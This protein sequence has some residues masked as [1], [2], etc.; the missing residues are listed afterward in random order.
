[1]IDINN[2]KLK[3]VLIELLDEI[4][5]IC[6][7]NNLTYFLYAGSLLGA[8]RH[9]GF[10]PWDDDIDIAMPRKDYDLFLDLFE[11]QENTN[12]Y[13]LSYKSNNKASRYCTHFGKF[14]KSGT[15]FAESNKKSDGYAGIFIDIFPIDNCILPLTPLHTLVIKILLQLC[16]INDNVIKTK[17]KWKILIGKIII[18]LIPKKYLN[19]LHLKLYT[20]FNKHKT[21][22]VSFFSGNYGYKR[23]T[24]KY[25]DIF[26]L[27]KVLFEKKYYNAPKNWNIFLK[28][29]YGNYM[30]IPPIEK[31]HSHSPEYIIFN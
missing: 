3:N 23:E 28:T 26:P 5:K 7:K 1:M 13:V 15:V 14:C 11:K 27:T 31:R 2:N 25:D 9:K 20:I 17:K 4:D 18:F 21:K 16:R 30:K 8:V 10:I 29:L 24:H 6:N 22:Y 19:K 12:Y